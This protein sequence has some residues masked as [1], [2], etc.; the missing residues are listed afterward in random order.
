MRFGAN[1]AFVSD[2]YEKLTLLG[3]W[4]GSRRPLA[5]PSTTMLEVF[6]LKRFNAFLSS[7]QTEGDATTASFSDWIFNYAISLT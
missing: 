1:L 7:L 6:K 2:G 5:V 3:C 4:Y